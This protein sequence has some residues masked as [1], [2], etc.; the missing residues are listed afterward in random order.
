MVATCGD[1][2]GSLER[3]MSMKPTLHGPKKHV[4][5]NGVYRPTQR[6]FSGDGNYRIPQV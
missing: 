1:K 6:F 4:I 2:S 5:G 3:V